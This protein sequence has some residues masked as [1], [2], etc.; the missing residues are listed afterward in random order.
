MN[1][2]NWNSASRTQHYKIHPR[3]TR[4]VFHLQINDPLLCCVHVPAARVIITPHSKYVLS[5]VCHLAAVSN[6][7]IRSFIFT[8][9]ACTL[10]SW[11]ILLRSDRKVFRLFARAGDVDEDFW[12]C[13]Y[14]KLHRMK[15]KRNREGEKINSLFSIV[16]RLCNEAKKIKIPPSITCS[17]IQ[18]HKL[19]QRSR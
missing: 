2:H 1:N 4:K 13:W 9:T 11:W 12:E 15:W 7:T 18:R 17:T 3:A 6:A 16:F 10:W 19:R 5:I 14:L 8:C